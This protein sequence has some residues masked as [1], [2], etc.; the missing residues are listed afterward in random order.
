MPPPRI[1][2]FVLDRGF[3]VIGKAELDPDYMTHWL[4][5]PGRTIRRWGTDQGLAQLK[6]GPM[7]NTVLDPPI[8]RHI[9]FRSIIE[10]LEVEQ[11]AWIPHLT[12]A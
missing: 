5:N 12:G 1:L 10:I 8:I 2:L 6:N 3:V 4:L 11:K 9:P 7:T